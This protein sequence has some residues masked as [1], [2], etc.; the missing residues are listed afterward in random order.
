LFEK[1][2]LKAF[3]PQYLAQIYEKFSEKLENSPENIKPTK[4]K[5]AL[6]QENMGI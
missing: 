1:I 3:Y 5:Y 2:I 6:N 4:Y